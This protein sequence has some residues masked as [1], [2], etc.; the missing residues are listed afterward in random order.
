M[1]LLTRLPYPGMAPEDP[2]R[3]RW[4]R[5]A[6]DWDLMIPVVISIGLSIFAVWMYVNHILPVNGTK[7]VW[8]R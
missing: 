7:G 8:T 3:R 5:R 4:K 2:P 1:I 6:I